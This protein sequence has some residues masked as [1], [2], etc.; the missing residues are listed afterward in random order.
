[1]LREVLKVARE[2][3]DVFEDHISLRKKGEI[4][5]DIAENYA[6]NVLVLSNHGLF[7]GHAGVRQCAEIMERLM[8]DP[9][10]NYR[11]KSVAG[12]IAY[13][14]WTGKSADSEICHGTDTLVI[15][16]GR[17]TVQTIYYS[18]DEIGAC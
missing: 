14:T 11:F 5:K 6:E 2:P 4:E 15:E 9:E 10:F 8:P 3:R 16:N 13:V 17:I 7:M 18:L 1:M 12:R